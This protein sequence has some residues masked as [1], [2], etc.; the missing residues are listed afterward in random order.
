MLSNKEKTEIT[1]DKTFTPKQAQ[2][3]DAQER[4]I[5][6]VTGIQG[7]KTYTGA[8]WAEEKMHQF[9]SDDGMITAPTYKVLDQ[10]T[11]PKFFTEFPWYRQFYKKGDQAIDLPCH[12]E[13]GSNCTDHKRGRVYIRS[14]E[15]PYKNEGLTLRWIWGDEIGQAKPASWLV[16]QA[17]TAILKGQVLY[18]TTPYNLGWLYSEVYRRGIEGDKD[19][20][21]INWESIDNPVFPR[22]EWERAQRTLDA[23]TFDM[24]YRGLFRK[25]VGLVYDK[26]DSNLMAVSPDRVPTTFNEVIA[27]IDWGFT[28]PAAVIVIGIDYDG[29]YWVIDEMYESGL[30]TGEIINKCKNLRTTHK[31]NVFYPDSAEPDRIKECRDAGLYVREANKDIKLGVDKMRDLINFGRLHAS[32]KVLNWIDEIESYHYPE[33]HE[34]GYEKDLPKKDHDDAM[35]A[36]RYAIFTHNPE[37]PQ[38]YLNKANIVHRRTTRKY[39]YT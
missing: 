27:G 10:A 35:D 22:D 26:F 38:D 18:T 21:V 28:H 9:P 8:N 4:F 23:V 19:F 30:T 29:H 34:A 11:L 24:R 6:V 31:I 33:G 14:E 37:T 12:C 13:R 25:R 3:F 32:R 16:H 7:G 20:R 39:E 15:D 36:T 2:I 5:L 17:R 1:V